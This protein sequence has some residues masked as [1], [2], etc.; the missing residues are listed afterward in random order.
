MSFTIHD[1]FCIRLLAKIPLHRVAV[2]TCLCVRG[3][4]FDLGEVSHLTVCTVRVVFET[5]TFEPA[6]WSF[7]MPLT[8]CHRYRT[9][10]F[11][12]PSSGDSSDSSAPKLTSTCPWWCLSCSGEC[13]HLTVGALQDGTASV[14]E[15]YNV[16]TTVKSFTVSLR[17]KC[18]R[19]HSN[20][21]HGAVLHPTIPQILRHP[22]FTSTCPWRCF[23]RSPFG[24][25]SYGRLSVHRSTVAGLELLS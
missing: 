11:A 19:G 1:T 3:C 7:T 20:F 8:E 6:V 12:T 14:L 2:A 16:R 15:D 22:S 25:E 18:H 21:C 9:S 23:A 4:V 10:F 5:A 24:M 13:F 17:K